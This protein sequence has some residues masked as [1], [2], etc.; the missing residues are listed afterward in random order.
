MEQDSP[1]SEQ[2]GVKAESGTGTPETQDDV[3]MRGM[4][5]EQARAFLYGLDP[6]ISGRDAFLTDQQNQA[7]HSV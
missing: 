1:S 4:T 6:K 2:P 3:D 7:P 5:F